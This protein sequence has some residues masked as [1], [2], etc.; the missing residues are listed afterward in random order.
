QLSHFDRLFNN[1]PLNGVTY[2]LGGDDILMEPDAGDPR[3]EVLKRAF[4][5]D[6]TGLWQLLVITNRENKS[7][8]IENKTEKLRG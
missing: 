1:P 8:T 3:R 7:K 4:R 6:N 5:V 2:T